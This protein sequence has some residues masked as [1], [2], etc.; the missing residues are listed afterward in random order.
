MF[1]KESNMVYDQV[2]VRNAYGAG[3]WHGVIS[4][5]VLLLILFG[6]LGYYLH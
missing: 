1:E 2:D 4:A 6:L 5:S 3:Y